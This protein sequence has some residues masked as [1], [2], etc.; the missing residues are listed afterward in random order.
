M[1]AGINLNK[2]PKMMEVEQ[3]SG[4]NA[5]RMGKKTETSVLQE[6]LRKSETT[7]DYMGKGLIDQQPSRKTKVMTKTAKT[8]QEHNKDT[9]PQQDYK[10]EKK[11]QAKTYREDVKNVVLDVN[12]KEANNGR[13]GEFAHPVFHDMHGYYLYFPFGLN[14]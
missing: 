13:S 10:E 7:Q 8:P 2:K 14:E 12:G 5:H 9:T 11:S 3:T 1:E 4:E 6:T